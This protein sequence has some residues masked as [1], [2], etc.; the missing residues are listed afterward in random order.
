[1][2]FP[3]GEIHWPMRGCCEAEWQNIVPIWPAESANNAVLFEMGSTVG[4]VWLARP[5]IPHKP[6]PT[7]KN[8]D[9]D[10][11]VKA[12]VGGGEQDASVKREKKI[13]HKH[14]QY[15]YD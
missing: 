1:M 2:S 5:D 7:Y 12:C 13:V 6:T 11:F 8:K 9:I 4:R 10:K 15:F 3:V 14:A